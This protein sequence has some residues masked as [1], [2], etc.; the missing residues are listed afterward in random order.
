MPM[1]QTTWAAK[2][3][4]GQVGRRANMEEWNTLTRIAEVANIGFGEPVQRGTGADQIVPFTTG[5]FLGLTECDYT[6][7][8][9]PVGS[10][11]VFP[12]GWNT[13][14]NEFG[15][16]WVN[17]TGTCTAGG[18]VYWDATAKGYSNTDTGTLIP[19]SEFDSSATA[20][21]I[22]KIRLRRIPA[23]PPAAP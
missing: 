7:V 3:A 16:M 14:V 17:A 20:G 4:P 22:V 10:P 1:I 2:P 11:A 12:V 6:A 9:G 19:N 15:V 8:G 18:L 13:P 5:N 23:A 21:G